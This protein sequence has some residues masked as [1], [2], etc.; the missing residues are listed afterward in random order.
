MKF[1]SIS[2]FMLKTNFLS[3]SSII[4]LEFLAKIL[5]FPLW[6]YGVGLIKKIKSLFLFI[7]N[8][9]R[10]LGVTIWM[11]N[12]FTPMYGQRDFTGRVVSFFIRLVQ[13]V[14]RSALMLV[15]IFIAIIMLL[16]WLFFP[17]ALLLALIFQIF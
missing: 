3:Y 16:L 11:K 14:F 2:Y 1:S 13:I 15:W 5:Y 8:K 9:N 6:W 17:I 12:I 7:K 4:L 10:E